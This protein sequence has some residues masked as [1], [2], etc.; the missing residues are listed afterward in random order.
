MYN[1]EKLMKL[2]FEPGI[3]EYCC[4]GKKKESSSYNFRQYI[5]RYEKKVKWVME[6]L[7]ENEKF[8]RFLHDNE[9]TRRSV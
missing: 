4:L 5:G 2:K 8:T 1:V 7:I 6:F 9:D 3:I